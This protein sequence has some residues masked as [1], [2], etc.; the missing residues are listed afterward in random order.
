MNRPLVEVQLANVAT[1]A[2]IGYVGWGEHVVALGLAPVIAGALDREM[3]VLVGV[4]GLNLPLYLD[5][6][7]GLSE[8]LPAVEATAADWCLQ[9]VANHA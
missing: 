2:V 8:A 9:G 6:S 4:N 7:G 1:A 5:F 3:P